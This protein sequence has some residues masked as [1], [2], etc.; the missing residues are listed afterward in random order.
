[1]PKPLNLFYEEPDPDRWLPY[2]RYPRKFIRRIVRGKG[3]AG[4]VMMV[5]L[6]LMQGLDKL[7]IPYRFNNYSHIKKHPDETACIIGKPH[8][9]FERDWKNPIVF[10]AGIFSHPSDAPDLLKQYP[11]IKQILVP[12]QWMQEM[13]RPYYGDI[14][15]AWP[16][17]ID[18]GYWS[19]AAPNTEKPYDFLI[20]DKIRWEREKYVPE[21]LDP[22]IQQLDSES[23]T[24]TVL[25]Y[26]AYAPID[27]K[28]VLNQVKAVIFLCEHETQGLAYQQI[29]SANIP[30][31]AWDRGGYWQDPAYYPAIKFGPV[32]SVPYWSNDCGMKFTDINN[33]GT[34][35]KAFMGR[36]HTNMFSPRSYILQ[37]LTLEKCAAAYADIIAATEK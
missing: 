27:L 24:Y 4:G 13:F 26:G 12:G 8:V 16:T 1:M 34:Q 25:R 20:Y 33:F 36:Y 31:L 6:N 37:H 21:L 29:L 7:H 10:G 2:D 30:I 28:N 3:R 15:T 5:A 19:P 18:S 22:I 11:N 14:V 35:L 9:L 17:G 23:R 32:S